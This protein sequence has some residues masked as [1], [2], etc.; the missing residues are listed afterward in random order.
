MKHDEREFPPTIISNIPFI[1]S[2][3]KILQIRTAQDSLIVT[4]LIL[5]SHQ[6]MIH[7]L[8]K[9]IIVK[10]AQTE[11]VTNFVT[12]KSSKM[13]NLDGIGV[14][15]DLPDPVEI[16]DWLATKP[17]TV[18][19]VRWKNGFYLSWPLVPFFIDFHEIF[20]MFRFFGNLKNFGIFPKILRFSRKFKIFKILRFSRN[21]QNSDIFQK[22]SIFWDFP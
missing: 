16:T 6:F 10:R 2:M 9:E 4:G 5:P 14:V 8:V 12:E 3:V 20:K 17:T 15:D 7:K 22:I 21:F 18:R 1:N 13:M 11:Y 19:E